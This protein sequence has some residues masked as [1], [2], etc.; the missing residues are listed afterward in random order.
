MLLH[1]PSGAGKSS[2]VQAAL[3][4]R[5]VEEGFE[6]LP[7]IR[8]NVE[9]PPG[10]V[11]LPAHNRYLLSVLMSLEQDRPSHAQLD[12]AALATTSLDTYLAERPSTADSRVLIFDQFEEVLLDLTDHAAK[13]E[14]FQQLGS[15]LR[16][17]ERWAL[18][19]VRDDYVAALDPY[20]RSLPTRARTRFR[21]DFL[22]QD[23]A[24]EA[25]QRP[26]EER[27]VTFTDGAVTKLID[28]LRQV[29]VQQPDGS[30]QPK[31]GPF[32]EPVQLQVVC[33]RLWDRLGPGRTEIH[34]SDIESAGTVD[35]ALS[36]YYAQQVAEVARRTG[37]GE[38]AIRDWFSLQLIVEQRFRGQSRQ[39]P[40]DSP[41]GGREVLRLLQDA[42]LIRAERRLGTIWYELAHDRLVAPVQDDNAQWRQL[43][44]H[45]LQR[46]AMI[47][48]D[49]DRP[50]R[51]LLGAAELAEAEEWAA[52]NPSSLMK[53]DREFL[54]ACRWRGYRETR[55]RR[56]NRLL[57][58]VTIVAVLLACLAAGGGYLAVKQAQRSDAA[59]LMARAQADLDV[60][61]RRSIQEALDAVGTSPDGLTPGIRDVLHRA[62]DTSRT[63][64]TLRDPGAT[65]PELS[66]IAVSPDGSHLATAGWDGRVR[67]WDLSTRQVRLALPINTNGVYRVAFGDGNRVAAADGDAAQIWDATA[68]RLL[69]RVEHGAQVDELDFDPGAARLATIGVDGTVKIWATDSGQLLV[70]L[71][72]GGATQG[73]SVS[74]DEDG[75]RLVTGGNDGTVTIWNPVTGQRVLDLAGHTEDVDSVEFSRNGALLITGS[76][77]YTARIWDIA[78]GQTLHTLSGHTNSVFWAGFADDGERVATTSADGTARIWDTASGSL[79]VTLTGHTNPIEGAA[80]GEARHHPLHRQLGRID[81]GLG[82]HHHAHRHGLRTGVPARRRPAPGHRKRRPDVQNV[83]RRPHSGLGVRRNLG[84]RTAHRGQP[85]PAHPTRPQELGRPGGVQSRRHDAGHEQRATGPPSCGRSSPAPCSPPWPGTATPSTAWA[86]T[87]RAPCWPPQRGA[88]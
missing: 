44:L 5:L 70:T 36:T 21:L 34:E 81:Q 50:E 69:R 4:G 30:S 51:L 57:V 59:A 32:V 17:R 49:E 74:F 53:L 24:R 79:L 6:V 33:L 42:H 37:T 7:V 82:R 66:D 65:R 71:V 48:G 11:P 47:W 41:D 54:D 72:L 55:R 13:R 35:K 62:V 78:T 3:I 73:I 39:G 67:V 88:T 16:S 56:L 64:A 58:A 86:G 19:L 9:Q 20:L 76:E 23:A 45:T 25:V 68:N 27:G 52:A 43:H 84:R 15:A 2:L 28:D 10:T 1:S 40:P 77:D 26:A 60:D 38:R 46:Q 18:F 83:G 29:W 12:G 63:R 14:F 61:P 8:V 87:P 75:Q 22:G 31:P 80:F 85:R